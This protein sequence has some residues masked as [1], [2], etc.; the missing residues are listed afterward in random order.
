MARALTEPPQRNPG[1]P[2]LSTPR[3]G[4][5]NALAVIGEA[6]YRCDRLSIARVHA[7]NRAM[8]TV[9]LIGIAAPALAQEQASIAIRDNGFAPVEIQVSAGTKIELT[10]TNQQQRAAEFESNTLRREK[11]IPPGATGTIY[12]GPLQPGS[13]EFYEDFQPN[14]RGFL[15]AK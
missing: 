12:V 13:Y 4:K 11:V 14:N 10:I 15:V 1:R 5:K 8:L 9:L 7:I 2:N 6:G 3:A